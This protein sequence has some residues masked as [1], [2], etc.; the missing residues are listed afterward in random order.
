MHDDKTSVQRWQWFKGIEYE[1]VPYKLINH[2]ST[3]KRDETAPIGVLNFLFALF[4]W[5][6]RSN[7]KNRSLATEE[8]C[9][10]F[11]RS[12][13]WYNFCFNFKD[14]SDL[15]RWASFFSIRKSFQIMNEPKKH[16]QREKEKREKYSTTTMV[17]KVHGLK[18]KSYCNPIV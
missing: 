17:K 4:C 16:T 14:Y 7:G 8:N 9:I 11:F 13:L 10:I 1:R 18:S 6:M 15:I 2:C 12:D 3:D 5:M